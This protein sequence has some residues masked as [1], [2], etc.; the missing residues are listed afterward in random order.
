M[1]VGMEHTT[2]LLAC[3]DTIF[4]ISTCTDRRCLHPNVS[5]SAASKYL[6]DETVIS[7]VACKLME[8]LRFW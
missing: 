8:K 1:D 5:L 3:F 7:S 4:A 2:V 6:K